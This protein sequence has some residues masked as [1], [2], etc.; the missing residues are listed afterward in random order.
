MNAPRLKGH[1]TCKFCFILPI[2]NNAFT[3]FIDL[4]GFSRFAVGRAACLAETTQRFIGPAQS[5]YLF[6]HQR[7][8]ATVPSIPSF[9]NCGAYAA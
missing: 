9:S 7:L 6:P 1:R 2:D 5:G 3:P 8:P 4:F